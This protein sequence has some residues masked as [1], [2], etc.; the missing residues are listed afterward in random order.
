MKNKQFG[1]LV[2]ATAAAAMLVAG[3]GVMPQN[4]VSAAH[5]D[6]RG[7]D[8]WAIT[9]QMT[10]GWNLGNTLDSTSNTLK[11]DAMPEKW[12]SAWGNPAPTQ[13]LIDTVKN[14]GFDTIRIP[15]TWCGHLTWSEQDQM[16]LVADNWMNYVQQVVDYAYEQDMFVILNVHHEDFINVANA[17]TD[18]NVAEASKKL[19]DIWTQVSEKFKDYD[20]HLIFEVL[21]EPREV[22]SKQEW[23]GGKAEGRRYVN[24]LNE[25]AFN[26]IRNNGSAANKERL[27]MLTP[28]GANTDAAADLTIPANAGNVAISTHAYAPYYFTMANDEN[29]NHNWP[30]QSGWGE[31]YEMALDNLFNGLKSLSQQKN[32]PIIMGEF[33]ASDFGNTDARVAWAKAYLSRAK[34]AGVTCVL[35]DN[36]VIGRTD[37]EAHGYVYRKTNTWYNES[38]PVIK[39]M[40]EVYNRPCTLP[41]YVPYVAP[42][43]SWDLIPVEDNWVELFKVPNGK[44]YK[45]WGNGIVTGWQDYINENYKMVVVYQSSADPELVLQGDG[46]GNWNRLPATDVNSEGFMATFEYNDIVAALGDKNVADMNNLYI[47]AT[48]DSLTAYGVY[49]VPVGGTKPT[50]EETLAPPVG[51]RGDINNDNQLTVVDIVELQKFLLGISKLDNM[52]AADMNSDNA[53]NVFDLALL[54]NAVLASAK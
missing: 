27:I 38:A 44:T 2:S 37:G 28:Y 23:S 1:R 48:M 5:T 30:G 6:L 36:N 3:V 8:A 4:T 19:G 25:V 46:E 40:M 43:F 54:K 41:E 10:I 39:A 50:E 35:W 49:A 33:S 22:G 16:Y 32:A 7:Q 47:S 14:G 12:A 9:N 53:I 34:D 26:A 17:Y 11:P 18:E 45:E 29:A 20:Q 24:Q 51:L 13:E 15:T 21:N 52:S 31:D 42:E